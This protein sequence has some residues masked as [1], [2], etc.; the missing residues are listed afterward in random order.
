MSGSSRLMT[1]APVETLYPGQS[2]SVA[3]QP[4]STCRRS[5]THTDLPACAR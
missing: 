4:P 2:A 5:R 1:Y 3:A